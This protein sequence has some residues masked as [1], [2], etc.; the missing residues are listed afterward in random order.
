MNSLTARWLLIGTAVLLLNCRSSS[1]PPPRPPPVPAS[2]IWVGGADGGVFLVFDKKANDPKQIY[3]AAIYTEHSGDIWFKGKLRL[4]ASPEIDPRVYRD[5]KFF[6]G[7]DG[8]R[9]HLSDG[10]QLT[11]TKVAPVGRQ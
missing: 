4:S 2:A 9:L 7:W 8:E 6:S 5:P 3:D 1:G 10:R 11:V